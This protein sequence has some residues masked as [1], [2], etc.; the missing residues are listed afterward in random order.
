MAGLFDKDTLAQMMYHG[1]LGSAISTC[2]LYASIE[3]FHWSRKIN[4][5]AGQ[6]NKFG[7]DIERTSRLLEHVISSFVDNIRS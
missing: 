1:S 4:L 5:N 2:T 3:V 6:C 7:M